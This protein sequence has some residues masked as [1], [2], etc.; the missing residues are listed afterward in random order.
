MYASAAGNAARLAKTHA[1][2]KGVSTLSVGPSPNWQTERL[3][4]LKIIEEEE[5]TG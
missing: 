1:Q 5:G 2:V 4:L 3:D